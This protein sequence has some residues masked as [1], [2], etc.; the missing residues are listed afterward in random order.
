[1]FC[2]GAL[3]LAP[4][5]RLNQAVPGIPHRCGTG[6][7]FV[8]SARL[9]SSCASADRLL[10]TTSQQ[11]RHGGRSPAA[12]GAGRGPPP[13]EQSAWLTRLVTGGPPIAKTRHPLGE[14]VGR[15]EFVIPNTALKSA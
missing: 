11:D 8:S 10:T 9:R 12:L 5:H 15:L 6:K 7:P 14:S 13:C 4:P 2:Q 3:H 1:N